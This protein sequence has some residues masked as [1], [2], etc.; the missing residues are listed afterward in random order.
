MERSQLN[1]KLDVLWKW[2]IQRKA[3]TTRNAAIAVQV[4]ARKGLEENR[5]DDEKDVPSGDK[6]ASR[7]LQSLSKSTYRMEEMPWRHP[8]S[9]QVTTPTWTDSETKTV[10]EYIWKMMASK[11]KLKPELERPSPAEQGE[12]LASEPNLESQLLQGEMDKA[13]EWWFA[14]R[15]KGIKSNAESRARQAGRV[16]Q[17]MEKECIEKYAEFEY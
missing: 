7:L 2:A 11:P 14:Y 9:E 15:A 8:R 1:D 16:W 10:L 6:L 13:W 4:R 17:Q 5:F 12:I 3:Y